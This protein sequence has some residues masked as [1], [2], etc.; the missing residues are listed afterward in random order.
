MHRY[1]QST[2]NVSQQ[3]VKRISPSKARVKRSYAEISSD[4]VQTTTSK[5]HANFT[6]GHSLAKASRRKNQED[7]QDDIESNCSSASSRRR[8]DVT[9]IGNDDDST[10][11]IE[12]EMTT[13]VGKK[14][15]HRWRNDQPCP[16]CN[17]LLFQRHWRKRFCKFCQHKW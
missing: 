12:S 3:V 11:E 6:S 8:V 2:E 4:A 9:N 10:E 17:T 15:N 13:S 16:K 14:A 1:V 5:V 7:V